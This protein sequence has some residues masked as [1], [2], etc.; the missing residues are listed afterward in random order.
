MMRSGLADLPA[1]GLVV[2]DKPAGWTSHSVVGRVRR[3][4][5]T[6]KVGHAG[7][8]D[9][10]AT[11]VLII[12]IGKATR[13]LGY[14]ALADKAYSATIRLGISTVTDDAEGEVM[15]AV[16]AEGLKDS[17]IEA[18]MARLRGD[19]LQVPSAVSAI[20]V[21]GVRSYARVRAGDQVDLPARP[22][23]VERFISV[24]SRASEVSGVRVLDLDVEVECSTGTYVRALARDLGSAL[25]VGG[26]LTALQR[27]RVGPFR[28]DEAQTLD[29]AE[30]G[31]Q[32]L[33]L[34]RVVQDFF[35]ALIMSEAQVSHIRH[36]RRLANLTLPDN[37]TALLNE[38]GHF[39]ALYRQEGP[40]AVAEIVLV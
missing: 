21:D 32:V 15:T 28:V 34:D 7:T 8:L 16:G 19:L 20:K 6:R 17:D 36:G 27:T 3:L 37:P 10:M 23:Q 35:P 40:D 33:P 4:A 26:H 1:A 31:L 38:T 30:Q 24:A 29:G 12:G 25:G 2:I 11:G 39:L 5:G 14:L 22:V 18:A 9:P 13:L